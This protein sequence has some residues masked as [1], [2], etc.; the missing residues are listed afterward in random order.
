VEAKASSVKRD[1]E[2]ARAD[3]ASTRMDL[4]AAHKEVSAQSGRANVAEAIAEGS[5]EDA[6]RALEA[7][8]IAVKVRVVD[9]QDVKRG[10]NLGAPT[11]G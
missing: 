11:H 3:A 6:A 9:A 7:H 8:H 10:G 2:E 5:A 4:A 1:L